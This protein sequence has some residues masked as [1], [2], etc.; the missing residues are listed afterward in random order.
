MTNEQIRSDTIRMDTS[1]LANWMQNLTEEKR[2]LKGRVQGNPVN[3][4]RNA[5][6]KRYIII[7]AQELNSRQ[8][9]MKGF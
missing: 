1:A 9:R 3:L 4:E 2:K 7:I 5:Y 6:L 8:V